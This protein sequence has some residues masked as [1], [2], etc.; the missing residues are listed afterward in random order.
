MGILLLL[1]ATAFPPDHCGMERWAVK[2]SADGATVNYQPIER[3]IAALNMLPAP[4]RAELDA[5]P[6]TRFPAEL[7][8]YTVTGYLVGF[9]AE[10]DEDFHIVIA[11]LTDPKITMVAEMPS[12]NCVPPGIKAS[13][14][15]LRVSWEKR[16]GKASTKFK[17]FKAK[18]IKIKITGI[19]FFDFLHGQTGVAKNG[20]ELHRVLDWKEVS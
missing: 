2:T 14:S 12:G 19:G 3:T 16:F 17:R 15:D 8:T 11:D 5:K 13:S 9:K 18:K 4:T 10:A 1:L 20:F 6:N 7:S